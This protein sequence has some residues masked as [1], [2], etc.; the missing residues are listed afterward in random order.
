METKASFVGGE[1][2]SKLFLNKARHESLYT[3]K[4]LLYHHLLGI[5]KK[6]S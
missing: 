5:T 2:E 1:L 6:A 4:C 3:R